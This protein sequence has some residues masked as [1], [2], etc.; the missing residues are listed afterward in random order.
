MNCPLKQAACPCPTL[1]ATQDRRAELQGCMTAAHP[2]S[3][4]AESG[5]HANEYCA[6]R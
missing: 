6:R 3:E 2:G 4:F 1:G 5:C